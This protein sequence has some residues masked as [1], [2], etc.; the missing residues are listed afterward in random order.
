MIAATP[1]AGIVGALAAMRDRPDSTALL[2]D[3][4]GL[5][6]LVMV[7]AEDR[8]TPPDAARAMADRD[9]RRPAGQLSPERAPPA[10]RAPGRDHPRLV[11]S[12]GPCAET[13][14]PD[15]A[16]VTV[17]GRSA[18]HS[19][20]PTPVPTNDGSGLAAMQFECGAAL[21]CSV[22]PT[23]ERPSGAGRGRVG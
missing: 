18:A 13:F 12:S 21:L 1:V 22:T 23:T 17:A 4:A 19:A 15:G 9:S 14:S 16:L 2:P 20:D 6:T 5:P 8:I 7:G 3:L 11:N 10:G